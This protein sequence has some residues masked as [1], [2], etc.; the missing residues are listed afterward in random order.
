MFDTQNIAGRI[1]QARIRKNMT[2][3]NL[4]DAMGVSYQAVSNWERGS[5]LPDISKLEQLCIALDLTASQLLGM[6]GTAVEK[7]MDSAPMTMR[8]LA[9]AAPMLPPKTVQE[10]VEQRR[11]KTI[12]LGD[13]ADLAP[14]LE[15]DCLERLLMESEVT[16]L[17]CLTAVMPFISQSTLETLVDRAGP[18][19]LQYYQSLPCFL[20]QE[21]ADR[22]LLR[23]WEANIMDILEETAVFASEKG[24]DKVVD[25][26]I[27]EDSGREFPDIATF[28]GRE[29]LSKL[30]KYWLDSRELDKLSDIA[31]FL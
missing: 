8:E 22:L 16:D 28:L 23:C 4:A 30:A 12:R 18:E 25:A 15:Q 29:S 3:M 10:R 9:E 6:E 21:G 20:S 14:C 13:I 24:L 11:E 17:G 5:S 19:D 7:A 1:R 27:A 2:Q 26:Y 31:A